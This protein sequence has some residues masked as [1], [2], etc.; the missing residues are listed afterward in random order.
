MADYIELQEIV[1]EDNRVSPT[2]KES[3][4]YKR[5]RIVCKEGRPGL[6]MYDCARCIQNNLQLFEVNGLYMA[7]KAQDSF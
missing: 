3:E 5:L 7:Y 6:R 4:V 1:V 2:Q